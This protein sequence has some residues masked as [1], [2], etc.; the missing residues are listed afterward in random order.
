MEE[1]ALE[2][3]EQFFLEEKEVK[4]VLVLSLLDHRGR[5]SSQACHTGGLLGTIIILAWPS[6]WDFWAIWSVRSF[7]SI[8]PSPGFPVRLSHVSSSSLSISSDL[9]SPSI[10]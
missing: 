9:I 1:L 4:E 8:L 3:G 2:K 7:L 5:S 10:C 6:S